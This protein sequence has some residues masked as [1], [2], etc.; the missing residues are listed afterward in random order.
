[1]VLSDVSI[2]RPVLATVMSILILLVGAVSYK[3]LT[4]REYPNID[5]PVVNIET[6]YNGASSEIVETQVT[7]IIE[8]SIAGIEG[9]DFTSSIS[10]PES[11][12]ITITFKLERDPNEA[13]N[14]VRDRVSRVRAALPDE[15]DDPV[16]RRVEAD[17]QPIIY[18][19]LGSDRHNA[20]E[21]SD[22]A[23][24]YLTDRMQ[25][26][27]GVAQALVLG[28][29][30]YAMR[31]TVDP[32]RLAAY[33]LTVQ[34]V[35]TALRSQNVEIPAGRIESAEREFTVQAPTDLRTVEEF[36]N[37]IIRST[38]N[39]LVRL[40]DVGS[41]HIG[42]ENERIVTRFRDQNVV[43]L[44]IV[45]QAVANPLDVSKAVTKQVVDI[46]PTLPEGM[47]LEI[48]YDSSVFIDESINNVYHA[49]GE[50]V[51]LVILIIFLFLRSFRAILIPIVT[52]PVA[53]IGTFAIMLAVGFTINTL[54]LLG[55]VLAV[56]LVVDDAIVV[57]ENVHRHIENGVPRV[58]A[59][60][61]GS[62]EIGFAI[63]AMT[64]TLASVYAP[65]G[66]M[67]GTTGRLFTEFAWTVAAAV[68]VSGFVALTLSPMMCSKMLHHQTK[69]N[70]IY[71]FFEAG[72]NGMV[73]G[74]R[75]LLT[76]AMKVRFLVILL[77][78]GVAS[79]S[80]VFYERLHSELAPVEDRGAV[81]SIGIAPEG[82]T[83]EYTDRYG[84]QIASMLNSVPEREKVFQVTGYPEVTQTI[85]F[86]DLVDWD[87]RER[88]QMAIA[89][90]LFPRLLGIPGVLAFALNPPSLGQ[91][92]GKKP[93]QFVIRTTRPY[94]ELNE[95]IGKF[96]AEVRKNPNLVN[97]DSDLKLNKPQIEIEVD[98]EKAANLGISVQTIGR[99][100][101]T[102]LGGR[103]VTRFKKDGEQYDVIV[104]LADVDRRNPED[105]EK[106]FVRAS[107]GEMLKLSN[108]A[109]LKETVTA[110]ALNHFDQIRAATID[111]NLAPGYTLGQALDF[112]QTTADKTL[113]G[114]MLTAYAGES[115]EFKDSSSN[116]VLVFALAIAFIF[117]LLAA[118]FESFIDPFIILF[119][120]PLS[121]TG[122]LLALYLT[123]QTFNIYSQVGIVTLIGLI[124][125]HGILIVE[126]ANQMR[127]QGMNLREAVIE[128]AVLRLRPILMTTG[129][130]VL[131][132]VPLAYAAGAGAESRR[133][134]GWVIVGGLLVGTFFTLFVIPMVYT[135][136][137]HRKSGVHEEETMP[138]S[139]P[140]S[141]E[142]AAD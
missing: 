131:G 67:S 55:I 82:S 12:Q 95:E 1:M 25:I 52:I 17:A 80:W 141:T 10:R 102:L 13:A 104:K 119:T 4:V 41:A 50:A 34:D 138:E 58:R 116:M 114:S 68:L 28:E 91:S 70:A 62:R 44:G 21:L 65:I 16:I 24:R 88:S 85:A 63:I 30:R 127:E 76:W 60:L 117:L 81:M 39:Y 124:T 49:I 100:L 87:Q 98:R 59:A 29:R 107:N 96:L 48:A 99:T 19:A 20:L 137:A 109:R 97:V 40:S 120:V 113:P 35:E 139:I 86:L 78:V 27:P 6:T 22:Y 37:L 2:R 57:L 75:V 45:K 101:E 74:Y 130:M 135:V 123:G 136:L 118:Q 122:A 83:L 61:M 56:G 89:G 92:F 32:V 46:Q 38:D 3:D 94:D 134:I 84:H 51:A 106:V 108:V 128:S 73:N 7:K 126:F 129:A 8:D 9:I 31:I 14:D 90:E 15:V 23:D 93:V 133:A 72:L 103:Q 18:M 121:I 125:K 11:S 47:T 112:L 132:S 36:N 105:L 69:H 71:N 54:T 43:G 64:L 26:L 33:Q 110:K 77:G 115:R 111:A 79:G 5:P 140:S 42:S 142:A 66:F 53:L